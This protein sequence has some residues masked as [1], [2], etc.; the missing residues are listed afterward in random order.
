MSNP[1]KLSPAKRPSA[2]KVVD[3]SKATYFLSYRIMVSKLNGW[4]LEKELARK[5]EL[6]D[7]LTEYL[8]K[9]RSQ[10]LEKRETT[11]KDKAKVEKQIE[12]LRERTGCSMNSNPDE[13]D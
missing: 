4:Q 3:D 1:P 7:E 10:S 11:E 13:R 12:I 8:A 6:Y 9:P 2:N 5:L